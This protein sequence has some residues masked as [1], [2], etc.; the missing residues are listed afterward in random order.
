MKPKFLPVT[1]THHC[2]VATA[3]SSSVHTVAAP[4]QPPL[5]DQLQHIH[6]YCDNS[7]SNQNNLQAKYLSDVTVSE[8]N[9][10]R[11][12]I[13][14]KY[15]QYF[16]KWK[17]LLLITRGSARTVHM[18]QQCKHVGFAWESLHYLHLHHHHTG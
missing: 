2:P 9:Q 14:G 11:Y 18:D 12:K 4:L 8:L 16:L 17:Q 1:F 3:A 13:L 10:Y 15:W 5:D 6:C 7:N